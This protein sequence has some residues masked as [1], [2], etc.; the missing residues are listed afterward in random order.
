MPLEPAPRRTAVAFCSR[1]EHNSRRLPYIK[2][3]STSRGDVHRRGGLRCVCRR[4]SRKSRA[5]TGATTPGKQLLLSM[6][7]LTQNSLCVSDLRSSC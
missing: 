3:N 6:N 2:R 5:L 7:D 4:H 1:K